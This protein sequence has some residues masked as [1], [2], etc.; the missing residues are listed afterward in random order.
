[1]AEHIWK[2]PTER[3]TIAH[4]KDLPY[5][6]ANAQAD[7]QIKE[8]V[9]FARLHAPVGVTDYGVEVIYKCAAVEEP[10]PKALETYDAVLV[11]VRSGTIVATYPP[12]STIDP[13]WSEANR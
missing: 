9:A 8:I 4:E 1:M 11:N 13:A 6:L 12:Y 10:H 2:I 7:E 3:I 5:D